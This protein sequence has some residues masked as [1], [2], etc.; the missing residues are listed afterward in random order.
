MY[1][2]ITQIKESII[3][4][5]AAN[6]NNYIHGAYTYL[7]NNASFPYVTLNS[8]SISDLSTNKKS[9]FKIFITCNILTNEQFID[10]IDATISELQTVILETN[11]NITN[12]TVDR[13]YHKSS[14][15][16][17]STKDRTFLASI[18]FEMIIYN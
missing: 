3:S 7:P 15:V 4:Q 16:Q 8:I 11:F 10:N 14:Y 1:D 6:T 13:I 17:Q 12:Y 2:Y 18:N 5:V 9:L